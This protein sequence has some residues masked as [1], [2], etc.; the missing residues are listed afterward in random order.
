MGPG[1]PPSGVPG[2]APVNWATQTQPGQETVD[3]YI[4]P[5]T[6]NLA[7]YKINDVKL[8]NKIILLQDTEA[9]TKLNI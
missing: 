1:P 9:F 7:N 6:Q 5:C 8:W 3:V 4:E 2:D